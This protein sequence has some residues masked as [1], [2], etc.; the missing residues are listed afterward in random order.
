MENALVAGMSNLATT[1]KPSNRNEVERAL[2]DLESVQK[3][4][5]SF[6]YLGIE[7]E[8][9]LRQGELE[10]RG[11]NISLARTHLSSVQKEAR[12]KGFVSVASQAAALQG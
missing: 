8:S 7:L 6:G 4:A 2:K 9:L 1:G 3:K 12:A 5:Q 11:G 10:L